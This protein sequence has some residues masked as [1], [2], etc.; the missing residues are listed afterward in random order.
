[1]RNRDRLFPEGL[2]LHSTG[3][4]VIALKILLCGLKIEG[5]AQ[6]FFNTRFELFTQRCVQ[7]MQRKLGVP[8]YGIVDD[9]TL[10]ALAGYLGM[11]L[12]A[13][14]GSIFHAKQLSGVLPCDI[15]IDHVHC[16]RDSQHRAALLAPYMNQWSE[17]RGV[18]VLALFLLATTYGMTF[19]GEIRFDGQMTPHGIVVTML[20]QLQQS[21]GLVADGN[22]GPDTRAAILR[23]YGI[24]FNDLKWRDFV[25]PTVVLHNYCSCG[26]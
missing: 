8:T 12:R 22:F 25:E 4:G 7:Q 24:D 18:N 21:L 10:R 9:V 6:L 19:A 2:C 17:G 3:K 14:P 13:I 1:M 5:A 16:G 15:L 26:D 20:T 23:E 11:D